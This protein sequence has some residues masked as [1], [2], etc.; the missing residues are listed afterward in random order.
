[1]SIIVI[2]YSLT[3]V[4]TTALAVFIYLNSPDPEALQ[5]LCGQQSLT[6]QEQQQ[7]EVDATLGAEIDP[8]ANNG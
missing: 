7:C 8:P 3:T 1:M 2:L 6:V 4:L 5:K